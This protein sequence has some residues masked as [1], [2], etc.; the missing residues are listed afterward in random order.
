MLYFGFRL[1]AWVVSGLPHQASQAL[2][3]LVADIW[4][5]ANPALR[6]NLD[7]NLALL[8]GLGTRKGRRAQLARKAVR[9]FARA[10]AD[11]LYLPRVNSSNL[12]RFVALEEFEGIKQSLGRRPAIF[13]TAHLGSWEM[14]AAAAGLLGIDLHVI[15]WDHPDRR[16]ANLFRAIRE[17]KGVKMM[18]VRNAAR[19]MPAVLETSSVGLA[20]DRDFTGQG[21]TVRL[22]GAE[23]R[24]PSGYAALAASR[25][26]PVIPV[27]CL[28]LEDGRYHLMVEH[29][30]TPTG[31]GNREEYIVRECLTIFEKHIEKYPEQWYRFRSLAEER[32]H[33]GESPDR[34]VA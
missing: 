14:A 9:N 32:L 18:S 22:F 29:A 33:E 10:V 34:R 3:V 24:V 8:P 26:I 6:R 28:R 12:D 4:Y 19:S 11:F 25:G 21:T 16:I 23:T 17:A 31:T 15:V 2:A 27:F 1:A 7:R 13:L 30:V 20:G 5:A